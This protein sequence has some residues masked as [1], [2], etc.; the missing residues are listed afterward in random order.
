MGI[1]KFQIAVADRIIPC[2]SIR[3]GSCRA[4]QACVKYV[5]LKEACGPEKRLVDLLTY[6]NLLLTVCLN[7]IRSHY[8]IHM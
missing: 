7:L 5:L 1:D 6:Y 8:H 2:K 4:I 3:D